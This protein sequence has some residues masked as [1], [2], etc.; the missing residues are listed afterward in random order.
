MKAFKGSGFESR[1]SRNLFSSQFIINPCHF[2]PSS[3]F[4]ELLNASRSA[5]SLPPLHSASA[6]PSPTASHAG[7]GSPQRPGA[8]VSGPGHRRPPGISSGNGKERP[9]AAAEKTPLGIWPRGL[10]SKEKAG[11]PCLG[12]SGGAAL[13]PR[14][15]PPLSGRRLRPPWRGEEGP[16]NASPPFAAR[17]RLTAPPAQKASKSSPEILVESC[18][19]CRFLGAIPGL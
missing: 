18:Q 10:S 6:A 5:I 8:G 2:S 19:K 4:P 11:R 17:G 12:C 9:R 7:F 16:A 3:P 1:R 15:G 13:T 14:A